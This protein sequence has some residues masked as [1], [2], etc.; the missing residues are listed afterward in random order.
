MLGVRQ[1]G[2][3][4]LEVAEL[5]VRDV[6]HEDPLDHE[7]AHP[8]L[9]LRPLREVLGLV[10]LE[11]MTIQ[12]PHHGHHLRDPLVVPAVVHRKQQ[13]DRHLP[14]DPLHAFSVH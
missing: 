6:L 9:L 5:V 13:K 2:L 12:R 11:I 10:D 8:S 4:V 14:L 7:G 3:R 1:E